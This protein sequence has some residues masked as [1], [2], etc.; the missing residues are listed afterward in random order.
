[1]SSTAELRLNVYHAYCAIQLSLEKLWPAL[2][3]DSQLVAWVQPLDWL[4]PNIT[5]SLDA[6]HKAYR[7]ISQLEYLAEQAPR[8]IILGAG[9]IGASPTTLALV[10]D[11]NLKKDQFKQSVLLL[12]AA[13]VSWRDPELNAKIEQILTQREATTATTLNKFGLSRLHLK[14]CYRKLPVL[15]HAPAKINWTWAH[16]RS[17]KKIT[18]IQARQLLDKKGAK[19]PSVAYQ[20]QKLAY[21]SPYTDLAIVQELAP[22]LRANIVY[23]NNHEPQRS[24]IKGPVPIFFPATPETPAPRFKP[25]SAKCPKNTTRPIRADVKLDPLPFLPAIRAHRYKI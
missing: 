17:I 6:R 8:E 15:P 24:M 7:I 11:L 19:D 3:S 20:L 25:P 5:E 4:A 10:N 22:H 9:F 14:Q 21:L 12:K 18:P 13:H 16:T 2:Q 23:A 1:M